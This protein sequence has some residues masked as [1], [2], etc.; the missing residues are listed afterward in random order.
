MKKV[1]KRVGSG[2]LAH[3]QPGLPV[4]DLGDANDL[5]GRNL[6]N[7]LPVAAI[8]HLDHELVGVAV[9]LELQ[10]DRTAFERCMSDALTDFTAISI[11]TG[12]ASSTSAL[13]S[14]VASAAAGTAPPARPASSCCSH[15]LSTAEAAGTGW[16]MVCVPFLL[17][18]FVVLCGLANNMAAQDNAGS[19]GSH[20][21]PASKK[22]R[23]R[24][25]PS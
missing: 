24:A 3:Q 5:F 17:L 16:D 4:H 2:L 10:A 18:E 20:R 9:D 23:H 8:D 6:A 14:A 1:W 21:R 19:F 13:R 7:D 22:E 12:V 11:C 15:G 25:P